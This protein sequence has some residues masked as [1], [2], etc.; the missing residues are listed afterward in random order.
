M[1]VTRK[2]NVFSIFFGK[3]SAAN[4]INA[5]SGSKDQNLN[6]TNIAELENRISITKSEDFYKAHSVSMINTFSQ[7]NR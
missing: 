4:N 5:R 3:P 2:I 7:L 1:L 6:D